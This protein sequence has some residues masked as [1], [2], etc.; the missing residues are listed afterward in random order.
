MDDLNSKGK[1]FADDAK[2]YGKVQRDQD[3]AILQDDLNKLNEWSMKWLL[4][5]NEDKCKVMHIGKKNPGFS[6][7]LG[8]TTLKETKKEKDLGVLITDDLKS[9]DQVASAAAAANA[10]L[11][12]IRKTFTCL[13]EHTVPALY[14]ALVRPRMEYAVQ[15][16]SP[17]LRKDIVKLEKVQ[18]RATKMIPSLASLPYEDRLKKLN[19]TTLEDRR[20]R[21]D[22]IEVYKILNGIDKIQDDFLDLDTNPR[23]RGHMFKLKKLRYRTQKRT[24]FF[25]ARIVNRWNELPDWVVQA[26]TVSSFKNRYDEFI[27]KNSRGGSFL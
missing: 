24:M 25:T 5:F 12:R 15:A 21:G 7:V 3:R 1:L 14:K 2:I 27:S 16:W 17:Q 26:K 13:D 18:R 4:Q 11:W 9:A 19:L 10:M 20:H 22:M 8:G 6:Y 23:T